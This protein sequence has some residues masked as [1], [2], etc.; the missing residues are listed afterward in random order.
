MYHLLD[1]RYKNEIT[2]LNIL[3]Q[4]Q[5]MKTVGGEKQ[6]IPDVFTTPEQ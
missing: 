3:A 6:H 2:P 4:A 1:K 5:K